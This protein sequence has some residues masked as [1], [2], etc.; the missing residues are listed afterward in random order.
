[1]AVDESSMR[2]VAFILILTSFAVAARAR[3]QPD[4]RPPARE[5]LLLPKFC[6][7]QFMGEKFSGPQYEI[8]HESCGA[9]VNHYCPGLIDLNRANRTLGDAGKKRAELLRAREKT[10]YTL[11][12]IQRFPRCP[13]R[14]HAETT[15]RIIDSELKAF[16]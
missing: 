4:Y 10:L 1:M 12:G 6:W 2:L 7:K 16:R 13:I 14:S 15:L 5:A 11:R 8:P 3:A 9:F